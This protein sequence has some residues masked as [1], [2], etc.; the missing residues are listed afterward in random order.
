MVTQRWGTRPHVPHGYTHLSGLQGPHILSRLG[1][2][3]LKYT[4]VMTLRQGC[5]DMKGHRLLRGH[6]SLGHLVWADLR[7]SSSECQLG[8]LAASMLWAQGPS[9]IISKQLSGFSS[10]VRVEG[11]SCWM[12]GENNQGGVSQG[13]WDWDGQQ[14]A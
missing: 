3:I 5:Q 13:L 4:K 12:K 10:V 6:L 11:V 14:G 8:M 9:L 7:L 1:Q 2:L